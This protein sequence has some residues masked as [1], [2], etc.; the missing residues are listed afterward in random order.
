MKL[1]DFYPRKL[2]NEEETDFFVYGIPQKAIDL[3]NWYR[4]N[5]YPKANIKIPYIEKLKKCEKIEEGERYQVDYYI[6][7]GKCEFEN[8]NKIIPIFQ[9]LYFD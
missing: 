7:L 8:N 1:P 2:T 6:V 3:V 9:E 5:G 4:F